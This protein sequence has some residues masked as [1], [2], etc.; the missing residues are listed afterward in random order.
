MKSAC[1]LS[2]ARQRGVVLVFVLMVLVILSIGAV[3][4]MRS[5]NT[6]LFAAGNLA[7]RRDL[8][9]QGELAISNVLTAFKTGGVLVNATTAD[10]GAQN[11]KASTLTTN[12]QGVPLALLDNAQFA[13]AGFSMPDTVGA[14]PDVQIRYV[15]D[16]LCTPGW[17]GPG[18][19]LQCVQSTAAPPGG[20]AMPTAP[21]TPPT[22][23]VYRLSV[24]VSGARN[25]QVFM[26]TTFT[27]PD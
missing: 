15:I 6:S 21:I 27:K 1:Y 2:A 22:A 12:A 9:N 20:K 14:T 5:M 7:F 26:Q 18:N 8:V 24:R 23:S 17:V 11:Y 3:A 19:A 25:T 16:R 4:L 10:F 13:A